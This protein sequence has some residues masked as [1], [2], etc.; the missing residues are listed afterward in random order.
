[1]GVVL[2]IA[3]VSRVETVLFFVVLTKLFQLEQQGGY[4][5]SIQF[6]Q[7]VKVQVDFVKLGVFLD[8]SFKVAERQLV[9]HHDIKCQDVQLGI[10]KTINRL[11]KFI[12]LEHDRIEGH[13]ACGVKRTK[14][15]T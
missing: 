15:T 3:D 8:E 1:M 11:S 5:V 10:L 9:S 6:N 2:R 7:A 13:D 12:L 14:I 4:L